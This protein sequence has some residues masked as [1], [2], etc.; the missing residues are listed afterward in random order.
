MVANSENP[1]LQVRI[2][3]TNSSC[4]LE[5]IAIFFGYGGTI[6]RVLACKQG[7][8]PLL[9]GWYDLQGEDLGKIAITGGISF[10]QHLL[11]PA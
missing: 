10:N 6:W 7:E 1:C 4:W 2:W 5:P 11:P 8:T 9:D 3:D